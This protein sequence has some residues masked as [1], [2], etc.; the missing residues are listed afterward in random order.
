MEH[1][2][3][4]A[5]GSDDI[6]LSLFFGTDYV[7]R[8]IGPRLKSFGWRARSETPHELREFYATSMFISFSDFLRHCN[9]LGCIVLDCNTEATAMSAQDLDLVLSAL[10]DRQFEVVPNGSSVNDRSERGHP[11]LTL[12]LC[13]LMS[14][15]RPGDADLDA[16]ESHPAFIKT[17]P[18]SP[19]LV[20]WNAREHCYTNLEDRADSGK[21]SRRNNPDIQ[22]INVLSQGYDRS[23]LRNDGAG[24]SFEAYLA[25]VPYSDGVHFDLTWDARVT[26]HRKAGIK[27]HRATK[28][29]FLGSL[30][31][32]MDH[33]REIFLDRPSIEDDKDST[34]ADQMVRWNVAC[35]T[36]HVLKRHL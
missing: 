11:A 12:M 28:L 29:G 10:Q 5:D 16:A 2:S 18:M 13:G 20:S 31:G 35:P 33:V 25:E 23:R 27:D 15:W 14:R 7:R 30:T 24:E 3:I 21:I 19:G 6:T 32:K 1:L 34:L 17:R 22:R 8:H 4:F 9:R 36:L 26:M